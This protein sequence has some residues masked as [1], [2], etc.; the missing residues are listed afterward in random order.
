MRRNSVLALISPHMHTTRH[1][2]EGTTNKDL[3]LERC[4]TIIRSGPTGAVASLVVFGAGLGLEERF[5][6]PKEQLKPNPRYCNIHAPWRRWLNWFSSKTQLKLLMTPWSLLSFRDSTSE[7][8]QYVLKGPY[9]RWG[10]FHSAT[11]LR[12]TGQSTIVPFLH[13]QN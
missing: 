4:H 7:G 9:P 12:C 3:I 5:P 13:G 1:N 11:M 8:W 10:T 6:S 2:C